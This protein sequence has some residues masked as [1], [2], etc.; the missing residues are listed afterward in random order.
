VAQTE[1]LTDA[2]GFCAAKWGSA[3]PPTVFLKAAVTGGTTTNSTWAGPLA[4]E[5]LSDEFIQ[6]VR[7]TG[8]SVVETLAP[9]MR[10]VEV[11][12]RALVEDDESTVASWVGQG[13]GKGLTFGNFRTATLLPY[14]LQS[15]T[16]VTKETLRMSSADVA[17]RRVLAAALT[18]AQDQAFLSTAAA[19]PTSPAG[20]LDG[21]APTPSTG[22]SAIDIAALFESFQGDLSTSYL[23]MH[24]ATAASIGVR[25]SLAD[26]GARGGS[27]AGVPVV[28]SRYVPADSSGSAVILLDA[29]QILFAGGP[30]EIATAT[31]ATV[32]MLDNPTNNSATGTATTLVSLWQT[33]SAALRVERFVSWQVAR[34]E[35]VAWLSGVNY[36]ATAST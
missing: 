28:T 9:A 17:L 7:S 25:N 26:V 21:V 3:A 35:A 31:H 33:N 14:K 22:D 34:P 30:V 10:P 24:P 2:H 4:Y 1:Y 12:T 29:Q 36:A 27:L 32:E 8:R 13:A 19:T 11:N 23:V 6:F 16:V 20:I 15:T 5:A 18:K